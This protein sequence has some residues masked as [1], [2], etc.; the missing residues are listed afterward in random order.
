MRR[1]FST[2]RD[3]ALTLLEEG[4]KSEVTLMTLTPLY[5]MLRI[6][7]IFSK[8]LY[9]RKPQTVD[10]SEM[11]P[12]SGEILDLGGG[13]E[14]VIGRLFGQRVTAVDQRQEELDEAPEGPKKVVADARD[15]PFPDSS[16]DSATAFYFLMYVKPEAYR[17]IFCEAFRILKA[18]GILYIWDTVIP[19]CEEPIRK[20][21][22]VP[23]TVK[24]GKKKIQTAY[25]VGWKDH[26]LS[27]DQLIGIAR[28]TGF[29]LKLEEHRE[30]AFYLELTKAD[31][32]K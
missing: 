21:F 24:I 11:P 12:I 1:I 18:G 7:N 31:H 22:A 29:S 26:S 9:L 8:D 15:L 5:W 28:K 25:G 16:F 19:V 27:S 23:V 14:G 30:E 4:T 20:I 32:G 2:D 3:F 10:F 6:K 13:G 17:Q